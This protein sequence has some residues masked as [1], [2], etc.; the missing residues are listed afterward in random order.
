[1]GKDGKGVKQPDGQYTVSITAAD[2]TG[3]SVT[4]TTLMQGTITGITFQN[5]TTYLML[6][7]GQKIT[8]GNITEIDNKKGG[9]T[10]C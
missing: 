2:S 10:V 6:D 9:S 8:F 5:N 1:M 4:A 3:A 7:N